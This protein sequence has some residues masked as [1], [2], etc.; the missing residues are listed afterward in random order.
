[1][2]LLS[3]A[4]DVGLRSVLGDS[5]APQ[6][7]C[8]ALVTDLIYDKLRVVVGRKGN[9]LFGRGTS[10]AGE[11]SSYD[12]VSARE[13]LEVLKGCLSKRGDGAGDYLI[14]V[15]NELDTLERDVQEVMFLDA[16]GTICDDSR[17]EE[18]RNQVSKVFSSVFAKNAGLLYQ[19]GCD[20]WTCKKKGSKEDYSDLF[21]GYVAALR[22][23][24]VRQAIGNV[25]VGRDPATGKRI[26]KALTEV[27][28]ALPEDSAARTARDA[29]EKARATPFES[30]WDIERLLTAAVTKDILKDIAV[31]FFKQ[32][33]KQGAYTDEELQQFEAEREEEPS[34]QEGAPPPQGAV[35]SSSEELQQAEREEEPSPQGAV[36]TSSVFDRLKKGIVNAAD[37]GMHLAAKLDSSAQATAD[38]A[39]STSAG[40]EETYAGA[41][42]AVPIMSMFAVV[43]AAVAIAL[44]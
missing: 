22:E 5:S 16:S 31:S 44:H 2:G 40:P 8:H 35:S 23:H 38:A 36:S 6:K 26:E 24:I 28:E 33:T 21:D 3:F 9:G 25:Y 30:V 14:G 41:P 1:M 29:I 17:E 32:V 27:L 43:F 15:L 10:G 42:V 39:A 11:L 12:T 20:W 7:G 13:A 34:P 37:T 4:Q 18:A 19:L